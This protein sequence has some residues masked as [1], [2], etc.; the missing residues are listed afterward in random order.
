[1]WGNGRCCWVSIDRCCID[2]NTYLQSDSKVHVAYLA[3]AQAQG[4]GEGEVNYLQMHGPRQGTAGPWRHDP[5]A[6]VYVY[7]TDL[8]LWPYHCQFGNSCINFRTAPQSI[9]STGRAVLFGGVLHIHVPRCALSHTFPG[10]PLSE[11][12]RLG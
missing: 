4:W 11:S 3:V 1:M 2:T 12:D 5:K 9:P 10:W 6:V 8:W 7:N